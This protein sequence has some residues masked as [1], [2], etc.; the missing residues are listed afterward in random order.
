MR[1]FTAVA[2]ALLFLPACTDQA[3]T[4]AGPSGTLRGAPPTALG[5]VVSETST[6]L[7]AR[8]ITGET[9]PGS[10]Y[11]LYL[12][13]EWN[14]T[15]VFYAHGI[16]D[17]LEPVS[18]RN[19]DNL[20]AIRDEL[21]RRGFAVAY[22]SFDENGYAEKDG[23]QRT[24]QLRGLFT[25]VFGR[26]TS[27]LL[28][29][30][31]LGGLIAMDLAERFAGQYDGVA[32]LCGVV[33]GTQSEFD[34]MVTTRM[35]F[36]MFY[37]GVLPGAYNNPPSG[38]IMNPTTQ[39]QIVGAITLNPIGLAAIGSVKQANLQF[40][41]FAPP[42]ERQTQMVT[43]LITAL[44]FHARGADNVLPLMNGFPFDNTGTVYTAAAIPLL[45][46]S[47]LGA[48]IGGINANAPRTSGDPSALNYTARNFTPSGALQIPTITLHNQWDPLVPYFHEG[49]LQSR[50]SAA[51]ASGLLVQRTKPAYGHCNFDVPEQV[52]AITDLANWVETGVK[53]A[54]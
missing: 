39:A 50:V 45:P 2:G 35:L 54:N 34:H 6:D 3:A 29:G 37:P 10:Q 22:S 31:S 18:L 28:V 19:Q 11:Q 47:A 36:D 49:L 38:F 4:I 41:V 21:G 24:H 52:K 33:G 26:P 27:S 48:T 17:V 1:R 16:R 43:S 46:N 12:P 13:R 42:A 9:G 44:T 14:G 25:S 23:A 15:A 8:I 53:P 5:N 32:A 51:G 40:N 30:H 20:Q 7:W